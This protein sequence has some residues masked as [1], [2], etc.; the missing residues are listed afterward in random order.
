MIEQYKFG[1]I[2]VDGKAYNHD[3][4]IR[5]TD[6]VLPWSR[7]E[8]H[9]IEAEDVKRAIEQN[10]DTIIIGIGESGKAEV[11][12]EAKEIIRSKGIELIIDLTEQ[13]TRTFNVINDESEE[14]EGRQR[15]VIGFFHLTC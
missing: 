10:P 6:E 8:S 5:W 3:I 1:L 7:K 15:K 9:I 14:E 4:E 11:A 12:E 2:V 13:A